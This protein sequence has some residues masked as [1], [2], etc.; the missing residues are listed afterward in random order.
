MP[1][2]E[3][4]PQPSLKKRSQ[5]FSDESFN[6]FAHSLGDEEEIEVDH[7]ARSKP[8]PKKKKQQKNEVPLE[9]SRVTRSKARSQDTAPKGSVSSKGKSIKAP[10]HG[11][12]NSSKFYSDLNKKV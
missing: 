9:W 12:T 6:P 7:E 1:C 2:E 3:N 4:I 11:N 5:S 10:T 8:Q